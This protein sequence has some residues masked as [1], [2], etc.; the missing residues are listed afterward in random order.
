MPHVS[1]CVYQFGSC[2]VVAVLVSSIIH[3]FCPPLPSSRLPRRRI[4]TFRKTVQHSSHTSGELVL[5]DSTTVINLRIQCYLTTIIGIIHSISFPDGQLAI[6]ALA[7]GCLSKTVAHYHLLG[8]FS[9]VSYEGALCM[10]AWQASKMNGSKVR[11]LNSLFVF[12]AGAGRKSG[13]LIWPLTEVEN[14]R[15]TVKAGKH[16]WPFTVT[17]LNINNVFKTW[18]TFYQLLHD[19][20]S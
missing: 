7:V 6:P 4:V 10:S 8:W 1:A 18:L 11:K 20:L 13:G 14:A 19:D 5:V 12:C 16:I 15:N 2:A 3:V 17:L 9:R